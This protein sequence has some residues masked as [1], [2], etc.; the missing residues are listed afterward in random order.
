MGRKLE[1]FSSCGLLKV[2]NC[3]YVTRL[4]TFD[5]T[6]HKVSTNWTP[7]YS[8]GTENKLFFQEN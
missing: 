3:A 7:L 4:S 6:D 2:I 8:G 1:V 5:I